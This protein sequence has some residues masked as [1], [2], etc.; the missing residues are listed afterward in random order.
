MSNSIIKEFFKI[1]CEV[2]CCKYFKQ[3]RNDCSYLDNSINSTPQ[4]GFIGKRY[5]GLV[6]IAANPGIPNVSPFIEREPIYL[7][8]VKKFSE[9]RDYNC[10]LQYLEYAS[11]YM[12]TWRNNLANRDF[13]ELL[14]YNIETIAY[15]NIVKCRS[16]PTGSDPI[17][18]VGREVTERCFNTFLKK[19]LEILQPKAI[20]G[21]WK[22]IPK[23]LAELGYYTSRPIP[24]YSGQ[25]NLT[26]KERVKDLI[27]YFENLDIARTEHER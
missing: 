21:H 6:I 23:T 16:S 13:R 19:Q 25:R 26:I 10:F 7:N 20:V 14:G 27:P 2:G 5:N 4:P 18:T 15:I 3:C 24:C 17:K 11:D 22:P 12:S 8:L 1:S 9:K